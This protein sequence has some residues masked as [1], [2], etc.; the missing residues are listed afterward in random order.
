MYI[1]SKAVTQL[2]TGVLCRL[3]AGVRGGVPP[4]EPGGPSH[5]RRQVEKKRYNLNKCSDMRTLEV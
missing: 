2:C 5:I 3:A 1:M 4:P